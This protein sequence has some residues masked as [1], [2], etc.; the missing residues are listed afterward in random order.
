MAVEACA[1]K[2]VLTLPT[3]DFTSSLLD[4]EMEGGSMA[5]ADDVWKLRLPSGVDK[6]KPAG[7]EREEADVSPTAGGTT[8]DQC[9]D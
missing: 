7:A 1:P 8:W 4:V 6:L 3:G 9:F 2:P 5:M